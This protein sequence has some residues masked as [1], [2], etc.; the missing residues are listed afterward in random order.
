MNHPDHLTHLETSIHRLQQRLARIDRLL[1]QVR[2][3]RIKLGAI[4]HHPRNP[5]GRGIEGMSKKLWE[6]TGDS[7]RSG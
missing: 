3:S 7:E 1:G 5:T 6:A 2:S 4:G